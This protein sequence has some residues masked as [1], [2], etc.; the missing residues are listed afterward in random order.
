[1]NKKLLFGLM[2][3]AA[4]AACTNDDFDSQQ[5]VAEGTSPI[6]FE[7]INNNASMRASM[8]GN[9]VE[10]SANDGDLFTLYHGGAVGGT[11]YE[12]TGYENATYKSTKDASSGT[13]TLTTPSMI[14]DGPAIMIWPVDTVFR[15][16]VPAGEL[17]IKIPVVQGGKDEKGKEIIQHQIPYVS[18]LLT[19][20]P[21]ADYNAAPTNAYKTAGKDRKYKIYMRP[22]ASQL[23]L[24][25][26]YGD[27]YATIQEL[28]GG[29]D[30]IDPI[31]VTSV[32][33]LTTTGGGTT[34]FTREIPLKFTAKSGTDNTRWNA[35]EPYNAWSHVTGVDVNRITAGIAAN[36][37]QTDK[38]TTKCLTG[39]DGCKFLILPQVNMAGAVENA[40]IVVNTIY[41]KV[42]IAD[43]AGLNPHKTKYTPAEYADAWYRY[44]PSAQ[45]ITTATT[46]E[47]VSAASPE[48]SG[49]NAGLFKTV[50][51]SPAL[52]MAQTINYMS[53][54][55]RNNA[56]SIVNTEPMGVALNR[57]VNV[58]LTHL[59]MSDLHIK[60]DKQLRDAARVW[61]KMNLD[62]VT[63]YLDGDATGKFEISQTTIAK[64]NEINASITS[65]P[66]SFKVKPCTDGGEA[67]TKIVITGG[68]AIKDLAFIEDNSGTQADV[69]LKAG[70]NW[71]WTTNN[72]T[73]A[74]D[75][76]KAIKV[77][78]GVQS[79]INEGTF[80]SGAATIAT[81]N[82][83]AAAWTNTP[84]VNAKG[85]EWNVT[86]GDLTVQFNVTNYGT[87]N[88]SNGAEYHQDLANGAVSTFVNEATDL[89]TRFG[90]DDA[91][92]GKVVNKGVFAVTGTTTTKGVINNYGL[93]KHDHANA[94]TYITANEA[95]GNFH[96]AFTD[97][98]NKMGMISL[99]WDNKDEDNISVTAALNQGF[100]AVTVNGEVTG[101]LDA[102]QLGTKVNYLIVKDGPTSIADVASQV[103]Y[104]EIDMT[105]DSELAWSTNQTFEGLVVLSP[106]NIK[107]GSTITVN[108]TGA[109]YL[110]AKMYV[111][112]TF[113]NTG[114][115]SGYYGNTTTK[116]PTYYIT[117]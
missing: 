64:I 87:V 63:V 43:P 34:N 12:L 59:D 38:L 50:A 93:I 23:N 18:D 45:K 31:K 56:E 11:N 62:N 29:E 80:A 108:G 33:L 25:A 81:C 67:C 101:A 2:S 32:D 39:N 88:I 13:A 55:V 99:P 115:W 104:L 96:T 37:G 117:Y 17:T 79:I 105:D 82:A 84:F 100:I 69:I 85:A 19:I 8:N 116:V 16:T 112:G 6:Q 98:T 41:G 20:Q 70:Q 89:P 72:V 68:D 49:D 15:A 90:G 53:A 86:A 52:G 57:Y 111:G 46:W 61:K 4:L 91:E 114:G 22:M 65:G 51:I 35:A 92:I 78:T 107:L 77:G 97:P 47:K 102:T 42:V 24:K 10:W 103:D 83:A 94:K 66:K 113:T 110:G 9:T 74:P 58:L 7:V 44:L 1:M 30:G 60:T 28:E 5:Q 95:G 71:G 27:T 48:A 14:K 36:N 109:T 40:G 21:Y 26:D 3:L 76:K 75:T 73:I 54:Y 106:V